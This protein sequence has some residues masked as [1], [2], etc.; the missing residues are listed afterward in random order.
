LKLLNDIFLGR[1]GFRT[2][3]IFRIHLSRWQKSSFN[4]VKVHNMKH[5]AGAIRPS[6]APVEYNS[7]MFEHLHIAMVKT[8]YRTSNKKNFLDHIVKCNQRLEALRNNASKIDGCYRPI[9]KNTT[10]DKVCKNKDL[11]K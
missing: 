7:N 4:L 9:G 11:S 2:V 3:D 1:V 8:G 5:Y 10:L 6:R